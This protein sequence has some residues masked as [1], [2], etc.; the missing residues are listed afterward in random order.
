MEMRVVLLLFFLDKSAHA[1]PTH[2]SP[3][4]TVPGSMDSR[5]RCCMWPKG[6]KLTGCE[7][8][9]DWGKADN[10]CHESIEAC[11]SCGRRGEFT[12]CEKGSQTIGLPEPREATTAEAAPDGTAPAP[13]G[14]TEVASAA[15]A[16]AET[17]PVACDYAAAKLDNQWENKQ[18]ESVAEIW[19]LIPDWQPRMTVTVDFKGS[20]RDRQWSDKERDVA[21]VIQ[22][23]GARL[24][25]SA[26]AAGGPVGGGA[27]ASFSFEL[28][29]QP[30]QHREVDAAADA[31]A[32]AAGRASAARVSHPG[33]KFQISPDLSTDLIEISCSTTATAGSTAAAPA[34][35]AGSATALPTPPA[36]IADADDGLM[37]DLLQGLDLTVVPPPP[38]A[39]AQSPEQQPQSQPQA[40]A[41]APQQRY[42]SCALGLVHVQTLTDDDG[43]G[44]DGN[45][46]FRATVQLEEGWAA[47]QQL[48]VFFGSP[49][50]KG[51]AAQHATLD[52]TSATGKMR[53]T[54]SDAAGPDDSFSLELVDSA[55]GG[56]DSGGGGDFLPRNVDCML[57]VA[58]P[59]PPPQRYVA[60]GVTA[61]AAAAAAALQHPGDAAAASTSAPVV[62]PPPPTSGDDDDGI[63]RI[64]GATVLVVFVVLL[65]LWRRISSAASDRADPLEPMAVEERA[66]PPK[67]KKR[68]A[69][70]DKG[71]G[72]REGGGGGRTAPQFSIGDDDD[73]YD[74]VSVARRGD[75]DDDDEQRPEGSVLMVV[76]FEGEVVRM[77][78]DVE[79]LEK[80]DEFKMALLS[81]AAEVMELPEPSRLKSAWAYADG[82][83]KPM[84]LGRRT[85]LRD[86]AKVELDL[87]RKGGGGGV[88]GGRKGGGR[89]GYATLGQDAGDDGWPDRE[90]PD[91]DRL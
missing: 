24:K 60:V 9:E 40:K 90:C 28:N 38:P 2:I 17:R 73:E 62:S 35:G 44:G 83:G 57:P 43:G 67:E 26:V 76:E 1:A 25:T 34:T 55:V 68:A 65:L 5:M 29:N 69:A 61:E 89:K 10:P 74:D 87:Q 3:V 54:L 50:L 11:E 63:L 32:Q 30:L 16:V 39:P 27:E 8:C 20:P 18:G 4:T 91:V 59:P 47:G 85:D 66:Q 84:A 82:A 80:A 45:G 46:R 70:S 13:A 14:A 51:S 71:G 12:F 22:T 6:G 81:A 36:D 77:V 72:R 53:F 79:G 42:L 58:S 78:V 52:S 49:T 37:G 19:I 75:A 88:L 31:A 21:A 41:A 48:L 33:F 7:V 64:K 23:G 56:A 86:V 15:V